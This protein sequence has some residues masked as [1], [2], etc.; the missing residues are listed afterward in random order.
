MIRAPLEI[1]ANRSG[2]TLAAKICEELT[3]LRKA[4]GNGDDSYSCNAQLKEALVRPGKDLFACGEFKVSLQD[5]VRGKDVFLVQCA[6][7]KSS[8]RDLHANIWETLQTIEALRGCHAEYI[9]VIMPCLPYSR[10]DKTDG[11]ESYG[12]VVLA[13]ALAS[14]DANQIITF[15][16]HAQQIKGFYRIQNI[17]LDA[18]F[19]TNLFLDHIRSAYKLNELIVAAP[20]EGGGKRAKYYADSLF[21]EEN[22]DE[23]KMTNAIKYRSKT[24]VNKID[25]LKILGNV[26][27]KVVVVADDLIDTAGTMEALVEAAFAQGAKGTVICATHAILSDPAA[28]RLDRLYAEG[29][30]LELLTTDTVPQPADYAAKHP[31]FK[32]YSVAPMLA[33][34]IDKINKEEKTSPLYI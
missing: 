21:G 2:K 11:R 15:D 13:K 22:V 10:Q 23:T 24:V 17:P 33:D 5:S 3:K 28:K 19:V 12:S 31:W 32:C 8:S 34:I 25:S 1:Y 9:N 27:D 16:L 29:K 6:I 26:A 30:L 18:L 4:N 20:D 14:M 7:D